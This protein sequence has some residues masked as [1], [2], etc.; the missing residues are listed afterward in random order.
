MYV[1]KMKY[2]VDAV[3][4]I[5]NENCCIFFNRTATFRM[6]AS[7]TE[8]PLVPSHRTKYNFRLV[9]QRNWLIEVIL[10]FLN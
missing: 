3:M 6:N 2:S 8:I 5:L 1:R 10:E 9:N 7:R 4:M